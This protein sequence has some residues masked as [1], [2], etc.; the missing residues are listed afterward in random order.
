MKQSVTIE[1]GRLMEIIDDVMKNDEGIKK[2]IKNQPF[3]VIVLAGA[4]KAIE[5]RLF[6]ECD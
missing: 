6:S 4:A 1:K 5:N 3:M 2:L